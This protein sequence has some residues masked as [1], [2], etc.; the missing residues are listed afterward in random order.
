MRGIYIASQFNN[1]NAGFLEENMVSLITFD[2]G[3]VWEKMM[4]PSRDSKG[5]PFPECDRNPRCSLHL[6]QKF[7]QLYPG[8]RRYPIMSK[9]SAPGLIMATGSVGETMKQNPSVFLSTTA[10]VEWFEVLKENYLFTFGD[11]GGL[12]VAVKQF[13]ATETIKYSWN[14]GETWT[15][16]KIIDKFKVQV[17]GLMTEPGE[18]TS[19]FTLFGSKVGERHTWMIIQVNLSSIFESKCGPDDYKMWSPGEERPGEL[20]E[21]L[22]GSKQTFERRIAHAKCFNGQDY[23]RPITEEYCL[24]TRED[25]EC[26][27]GYREHD[28]WTDICQPDEES[29]IDPSAVPVPCPEGTFYRRSKGYRKVSGDMCHGGLENRYE[30]DQVS[31]PVAEKPEFLL[32]AMR[33][34]IRRYILGENREETLPLRGL[35][36]AIAVDFDYDDNCVYW[37]DMIQDAIKRM[38]LDGSGEH[39]TIVSGRLDTVESI[40]YDWLAENIYWVDSGTK[41]IEVARKT[42]LHRRELFTESNS[43]DNPRALTI[44]PLRGYMY[45][46]DW[47]DQPHIRK[48]HMDGGRSDIIIDDNIHWPN[49]IIIDHQTQRLYWTDAYFDRIETANLD[50]SGRQVL[51][52]EDIP[53]PYAI[54]VY[55]NHI[56]WDDWY[57]KAILRANKYDGSGKTTVVD[58]LYS[59]MDLKILAQSSQRGK[60]P[61]SS[62]G[63]S[64]GQCS[65]LCLVKPT[66]NGGISRSCRCD[67]ATRTV[68]RPDQSE[69]CECPSRERMVN[70]S[71]IT[72]AGSNCSNDEFTCSNEH[73]I[74]HRWRCDRDNDCGDNSDEVDCPYQTCGPEQ[75][76]CDNGRCIPPQWK[77]DFDNDCYDWSDERGCDYP[78]CQPGQFTCTNRR[79][80]PERWRCDYDDDCHDMSDEVDCSYRTTPV[81][82]CSANQFQCTNGQCIPSYWHCDGGQDCD[83]GSDEGPSCPTLSCSSY[84]FSCR[85]GN[86][87]F[88]SWQC[89]GE[90]DCGDNSDETG[91]VTSTTVQP[92]RPTGSCNMWQFSCFNGNCIS[93]W[94]KCDNVMTAETT[95]MSMTAMDPQQQQS[96][97]LCIQPYSHADTTSFSVVGMLGN[98]AYPVAGC[99]I[100]MMTVVT[101]VMSGDAQLTTTRQWRPLKCAGI[102]TI[103]AGMAVV[104]H[105][106]IA[107]IESETAGMEMTSRIVAIIPVQGHHQ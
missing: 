87:I 70:G 82:S 107:A 79:C 43:L 41:K 94:W 100:C 1:T 77:C 20:S 29:G 98:T 105:H 75:F 84:Q 8:S 80:I 27:F 23:D 56:Y 97:T 6:T 4:P 24:C 69:M 51:L 35:Q 65:Q 86:C 9:Q 91:C 30:A 38:C 16:L 15:T 18:H 59:V 92:T 42:G 74:P 96:V 12:I 33:T 85:N 90:D 68:T 106:G 5:K 19:V 66:D 102:Q 26:D 71:C 67:N 44:D 88:S 60:N 13:G 76:T 72:S 48:G 39:E 11:H 54:G 10:G 40:V 63:N 89:D 101:I 53:H 2:K 52:N 3:G 55:K 32:Y 47:G 95:R 104:F 49:G 46:T 50:G 83:D 57:K 58:N 64:N 78:T 14:E 103:V 31:C 34:E 62:D 25:F 22:M 99:V 61:C 17:Y 81:S 73:C 36:N 28:Y 7:S 45:W 93:Y 37:A 21:C